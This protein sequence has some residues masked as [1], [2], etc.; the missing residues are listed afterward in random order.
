MPHQLE[1]LFRPQSI[2]VIG[3]SD[4]YG[5][6]GRAVFTHLLAQAVAPVIVPVNP[7]HKMVGGRKSYE[8]LG[9]AVAE[10]HTDMAIVILSADKIGGIV[11]EAAKHKVKN[12]IFINDIEQPN[13]AIR[14]KL[15]R[16][17]EQARKLGV[18]LLAMPTMGLMG[19]FQA[20]PMKACAYVG[21]SGSIADCMQSYSAER[22]IVFSRF[23]TL[24]PHTYPVSTGQVI[25]FIASESDTTALLIHISVL[26]NARE[27]LSALK[28]AAR[29]KPVVVLTTLPDAYQEML[30]EQAL[31]RHH[32]LTVNTLTQFF[33]AA[34]LIHTGIASRGKN[35]AIISNTPQISALTLKSLPHTD[36]VL[37]QIAVA[38]SRALAK[39]LPHKPEGFNPLYLPADSAPSVFQA[40]VSQLLQDEHTDAVFLM[41]AGLNHSDNQRVAKM[42]AELQSQ[43]RKP[44]VLV[45]LGSADTPEVRHIFN[46]HQNLHFRQPEH[47]LHAL[48]QLNHYRQHQQQRHRVGAFHDYA[49]AAAAAGELHKHLRTVLPM[50]VLPT[51][52]ANVAHFLAA[53]NLE[54][55]TASKKNHDSTLIVQWDTQAHFGQIFTLLTRHKTLPLLPPLTPEIVAKALNYLGLPVIVWQDWLL[56][57]ADILSRLPEI[58]STHIDVL[59]DVK[60]GIVCRDVKL[61]LQDPNSVS[62][63][64][65]A[66]APYPHE[67]EQH[68]VLKNGE[69]VTLRP[70]R[71]EDA[72]LL[73]RFVAEQ[74]ETS[75]YYRFMSKNSKLPPALLAQLSH[76]DYQR[77][78]ALILHDATLNPLAMANYVADDHG[79]SCEFGISIADHLQGQGVGTLLLGKITEHAQKQGFKRI[80]A[81]IL[82]ENEAMQKLALKL[83]FVLSPHPHDREIMNAELI[84]A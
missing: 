31:E 38:T 27:L 76:P 48:S 79:E 17:A 34:K 22:G 80:R 10:W 43:S 35:L 78:F 7:S 50:S 21:Q 55:Q 59:H 3:A 74:S 82:Q 37:T 57:T 68:I 11:R 39:M 49:Y 8:S 14:S 75:R 61:N 58:Q 16:A 28:T 77:E 29:L 70:I 60:R 52:K 64:L 15:E 30:F 23:I 24:N 36:L 1:L 19:W 44:L 12:I 32:I 47:A 13:N 26:D 46:Q 51:S 65:N 18:H 6:T 20:A 84:F 63:S 83:G 71:P 56:N 41:Y 42:V 25:D 69:T 5:S 2:A 73:Q 4:R 81:E 9:D 66:F 45:W 53:L 67:Y 72:S 62:G 40:A 33:T 54:N